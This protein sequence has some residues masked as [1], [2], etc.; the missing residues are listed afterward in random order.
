MIQTDIVY[1]ERGDHDTQGRIMVLTEDVDE[2][3]AGTKKPEPLYIRVNAGDCINFNLTNHLP[4]WYGGD[5]FVELAQTN[6]V[7]GHIHLVKFDVLASDGSSNGWNYQQAA[8]SDEQASS[9]RTSSLAAPA[10]EPPNC[11][12]NG[13]RITEEPADWDPNNENSGQI[14]PG[15][16]ISER[17]Y[18]DTELRTVFTHDHHFAALDQN[19]GYFGAMIVEPEK[20]DF[21][22][23]R[24]GEYYAARSTTP[25]TS[26]PTTTACS[27]TRSARER[28][29]RRE[30]RRRGDGHHRHRAFRRL[31]R[32]RPRHPG[33]RLPDEGRRRL[34]QPRR[35]HQ[36]P[37]RAR[38]VPR[39]GPRHDGHQ[40]PQRAVP[41]P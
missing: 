27:T 36:R 12:W 20:M 26:I 10:A 11:N 8:F 24:T 41:V 37:G 7:G 5:A 22:N 9:T 32:V 39:R 18:A 31:P 16:T 19:R 1:N 2:V 15:Q 28:L 25:P 40:L 21:R 3:L 17:W 4:N 23:P 34:G 29:V 13:C 38:G 33:L 6:M 30:R 14:P 35:R